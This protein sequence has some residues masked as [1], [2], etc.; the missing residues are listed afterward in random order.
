MV[1]QIAKRAQVSA[2]K[3]A[4]RATFSI[5]LQAGRRGTKGTL[6]GSRA[7]LCWC[8]EI[9]KIPEETRD[10]HYKNTKIN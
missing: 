5:T 9:M 2:P 8:A 10:S 6:N 3:L 7:G 1:I 4:I